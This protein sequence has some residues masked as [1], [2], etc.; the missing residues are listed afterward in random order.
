[1]W[2]FNFKHKYYLHNLYEIFKK[3]KVVVLCKDLNVETF[4]CNL[5]IYI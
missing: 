2:F 1:M 4:I 3:T 5:Y